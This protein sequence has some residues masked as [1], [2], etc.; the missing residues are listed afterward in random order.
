MKGLFGN[1]NNEKNDR[2]IFNNAAPIKIPYFHQSIIMM[3]YF[4]KIPY[5]H[6]SIIMMVYS[7]VF[8]EIFHLDLMAIITTNTT[9]LHLIM[10]TIK[11]TLYSLITIIMGTVCLYVVITIYPYL[12]IKKNWEGRKTQKWK[13]IRIC[14]FYDNCLADKY[15]DWTVSCVRIFIKKVNYLIF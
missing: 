6:Q 1:P 9:F 2:S 14:Y 11:V 10:I 7:L 13:V 12:E 15:F 3:V 8:L 5:F 4:Q